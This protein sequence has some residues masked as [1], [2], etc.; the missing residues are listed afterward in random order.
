MYVHMMK[1]GEFYDFKS[2][3]IEGSYDNVGFSTVR[4]VKYSAADIRTITVKRQRLGPSET[5]T[6]LKTLRT[7]NKTVK[8]LPRATPLPCLNS[9]TKEKADDIRSLI[10]YMDGVDKIYYENLLATCKIGSKPK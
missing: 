9:L 4:E 10:K 7:R 5:F 3:A 8:P 1:D 6:V 2:Q